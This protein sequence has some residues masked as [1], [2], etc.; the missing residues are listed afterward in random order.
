MVFLKNFFKGLIAGIGG[1]APGLS[2]SVLLVILGLYE[3]TVNAIGTL[4]KNFKTNIKFLL[5]LLAGLGV[6]ILLFSK[7]VDYLLESFEFQTRYAF[8]GLILGTIPLFYREVRKNGFRKR[9][10]GL[11]AVSAAV[12][13]FLFGF[14]RHLFPAVTEPNL[15]QSV[16]LG[17]AV[18]G[19]SIVPGVDSAAIMSAFGLY[20]L[21][22]SSLA[23][24][25]LQI[26]IPAAGGLIVGAL[27]ISFVMNLLI[28]KAYTGT[29]SVIFGMF[30][31]IIPTVVMEESC[32]ITSLPMGLAAIGFALVGAVI[33]LYFGDIKGNNQRIARMAAKLKNRKHR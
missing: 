3:Q 29:F 23:D 2:G 31:A 33:S 8:L 13:F 15:L 6:G 14:N 19:S 7:V 16:L 10:Y 32:T 18:A 5:P 17:V 1:I 30:L 25:N 22:V 9:Y 4:F 21:Y 28:K 26:L 11:M 24:F 20:E 12:G 27:V